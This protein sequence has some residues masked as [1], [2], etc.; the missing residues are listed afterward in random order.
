MKISEC[1]L[2][3]QRIKTCRATQL[4]LCNF[5]FIASANDLTSEFCSHRCLCNGCAPYWYLFLYAK[6][7]VCGKTWSLLIT[8]LK[9]LHFHPM[10]IEVTLTISSY[11]S[12]SPRSG[13]S[14]RLWGRGA[15]ADRS[16]V[17]CLVQTITVACDLG[18]SVTYYK[19]SD[20][21]LVLLCSVASYVA[22]HSWN[23]LQ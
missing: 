16:K 20:G 15:G 4:C 10:A 12:K 8:L 2:K 17:S 3:E 6:P 23:P 18:W 5:I 7:G 14:L 22:S 19:L 21:K 1:N 9:M 13:H 11:H